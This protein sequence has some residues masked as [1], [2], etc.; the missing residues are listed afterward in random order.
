VNRIET[1]LQY[2]QTHPNDR[3]ALYSL[4]LALWKDG[5][6]TAAEVQL[7]A[8][9]AA[10]PDAGPGYFQLGRL[11]EAVDRPEEALATWRAGLDATAS[12]TDPD[13]ARTRSELRRE[14]DRLAED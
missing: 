14:I 7:R 9:L 1:F 10:H 4:A 8:L 6:P 2:L 12:A 13:A 11:L 3:F 5:Q